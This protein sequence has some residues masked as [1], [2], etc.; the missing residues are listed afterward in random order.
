MDK[1]SIS[2]RY[3]LSQKEKNICD[4]SYAE[5]IAIYLLSILDYII[6]FFTFN[7]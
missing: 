2:F 7:R 3:Q 5:I 6:H 4:A 1:Q